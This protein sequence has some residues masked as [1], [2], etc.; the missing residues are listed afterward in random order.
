MSVRAK[1]TVESTT[2]RE[3]GCNSVSLYPVTGGSDENK[4][5]FKYTPGG[6]ITMD[7]VNDDTA[8]KFV[9][10]KSYYVDFTPAES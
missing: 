6:K 9:V 10:G 2:K 1:F 7:V 4:S 5:F 3:N 8:S